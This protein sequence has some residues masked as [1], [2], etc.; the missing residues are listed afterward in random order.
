MEMPFGCVEQCSELLNVDF[1]SD[2][3]WMLAGWEAMTLVV[4][5]LVDYGISIFCKNLITIN[6]KSNPLYK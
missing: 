2:L 5:K 4:E 6:D 1:V 3:A